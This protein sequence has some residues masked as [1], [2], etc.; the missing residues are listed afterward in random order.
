MHRFSWATLISGCA[1]I[2]VVVGG[3]WTLFQ[4]QFNYIDRDK[5]NIR[6][7]LGRREA[8]IKDQLKAIQTELDHRRA[9]FMY[10]REFSQFEKRMDSEIDAIKKR[11]SVIEQ[12]KK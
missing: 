2:F 11:L 6:A 5:E 9:E 1:L 12:Q 10:V 4:T 7:E 3:G 8:E